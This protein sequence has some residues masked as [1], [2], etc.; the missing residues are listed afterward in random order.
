MASGTKTIAELLVKIGVDSKEAEKAIRNLGDKFDEAEK[1]TKRLSKSLGKLSD[2]TKKAIVGIGATITAL[3]VGVLKTGASFEKLEAQL[4][5]A[6]GSA[7][8]AREAMSFVREF[9]KNTPFQVEQITGAFIKLK[10]LGLEPSERALT[11]YGDTASAMGK[12]LDQL[13]EAVAD[14]TTGEFERLKEFGIKTKSEGDR[15]SFTFRGVTTTVGKNAKEIQEFL[16]GL[17]ETK[18]AGAMSEQMGTLNG[19]IS[20][21]QD[22]LASFFLEVANLGPLEEFKGLIRD[23]QEAAG[24]KSG[25]LAKTLAKI[26]TDA[27]RKIR[28]LIAGGF[29]DSLQTAADAFALIATNVDKLFSLFVGAKVAQG[30]LAI[31]AG[32]KAMGVAAAGA[33]GPIGLVAGALIA[34][35]PI[36]IDVGNK[37]GAALAGESGL[38]ETGKRQRAPK[39]LSDEFGEDAGEAAKINKAI[40]DDQR[41]LEKQV[42][43]FSQKKAAE[44]RIAANRGKLNKL[45]SKAGE[46]IRRQEEQ[47]K[48]EAE[49]DRLRATDPDF[50][51]G[52]TLEGAPEALVK[53][54]E[55]AEKRRLRGA[56]NAGRARGA[57]KSKT[58]TPITSPTTV[59]E[60]FK[61]AA[62]GDLGPIAA[63]TPS[64][65][66]IEPT[67]AV[68]I[69]NNNFKFE[70]SQ[71][72][73][74]Q[75]DPARIG[76]EA[77][78]AIKKEFDLRLSAAGQQLATSLVR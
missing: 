78:A 33:L 20:N 28:S 11:S 57:G 70:I 51:E 59:S 67:V 61:A 58:R 31:S 41:F 19:V 69:T 17:G 77:A 13:I 60:F 22:A 12:D 4:K 65:K 27:I 63:R 75:T 8:G 2:I 76:Q 54:I 5:T 44:R 7:D 66:D 43:T 71:D 64:V 48:F 52:P 56:F 25:G 24:D 29:V 26:L 14:A 38:V 53:S 10:N 74:G 50:I 6:T 37:I 45:K 40:R 55:K 39:F 34:L 42:F 30:F 35:I 47:R 49:Q 23:I 3:G 18:F 72:I 62:A 21:A 9:A 68:D 73:K 36:A 46:R 32:F 15:V 16:I 1:D